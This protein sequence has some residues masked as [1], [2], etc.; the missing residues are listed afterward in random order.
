MEILL[1]ITSLCNLRCKFCFVRENF[2]SPP[3]DEIVDLVGKELK[4]KSLSKIWV[5]ITGGEPLIRGDLK[6]LLS[7]IGA[8]S[9]ECGINLQTNATLIT[10]DLAVMLKKNGVKSA[11]VGIPALTNESY[12][13]LTGK[14][15]GLITAIKGIKCLMSVGIYVCLNF[16]LSRLVMEDFYEIPD[17]VLKNF[18][19]SISVNLSTL[20]PGTPEDFFKKYGL[21]YQV[22]GRILQDVYFKLRRYKIKTTYFGGDCSPPIC[23]FNNKDICKIYSFGKPVLPIRYYDTPNNLVEGYMYKSGRC[24]ECIYDDRCSGV[25]SLYV[26][27][28]KNHNF[29]PKKYF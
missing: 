3:I 7:T 17:F 8:Y 1:R 20:S 19:N 6:D 28:F 13:V 2:G 9:K 11:F 10:H 12:F 25:S 22:A 5:N 21:D 29:N 24:K 14:K 4:Y 16:V 23:A 27:V 26:R 18:G 15:D